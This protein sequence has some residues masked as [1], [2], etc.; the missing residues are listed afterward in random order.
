MTESRKRDKCWFG[1]LST[2]EELEEKEWK[3][4]R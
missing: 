3:L 4:V 1:E 2:E